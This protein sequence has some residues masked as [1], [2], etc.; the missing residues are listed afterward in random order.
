MILMR[1]FGD[2]LQNPDLWA[3]LG[4]VHYMKGAMEE[5]QNC[6]E[7]TL[8]FVTDASETHSIF[9]RLASIYLQNQEVPWQLE[10]LAK[11]DRSNF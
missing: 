10:F 9:L 5:A 1:C 2:W 8:S 6:Y 3:L 7:R 11:L 4:H